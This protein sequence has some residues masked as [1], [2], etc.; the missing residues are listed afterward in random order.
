MTLLYHSED[1]SDDFPC[2]VKLSENEILVEYE[3]DGYVQYTG[4]AKGAGHFEL[5]APEVSGHASLHR[6]EGSEILEGSWLEDGYRGMWRIR[7]G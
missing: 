6:F 1:R 2:V 4:V 3:D 7:L 5:S